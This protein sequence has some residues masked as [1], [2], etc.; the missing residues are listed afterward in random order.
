MTGCIIPS[1]MK[2]RR[3]RDHITNKQ[4]KHHATANPTIKRYRLALANQGRLC[5]HRKHVR[6]SY[7]VYWSFYFLIKHI[8]SFPEMPWN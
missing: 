7:E 3:E 4:A 1:A 2:K 8:C 6:A 5:F